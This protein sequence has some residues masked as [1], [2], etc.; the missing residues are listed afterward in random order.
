MNHDQH[1]HWLDAARLLKTATRDLRNAH[2]LQ[3][4]MPSDTPM[5]SEAIQK[6]LSSALSCINAA[7]A[8][9]ESDIE[10]KQ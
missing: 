6:Y 4:G 3:L 8:R 1:P 9:F 2:F 5:T 7:L 10:V